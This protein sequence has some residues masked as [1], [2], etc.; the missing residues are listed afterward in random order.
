MDSRVRS[1]MFPRYIFLHFPYL[2]LS[3]NL[4][5]DNSSEMMSG[6]VAIP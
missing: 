3:P 2:L 4:C 5:C 1:L 6:D